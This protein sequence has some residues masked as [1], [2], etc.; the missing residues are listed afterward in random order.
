MAQV[1]TIAKTLPRLG[2]DLF[3]SV[4]QVPNSLIHSRPTRAP[5]LNG[6]QN[7]VRCSLPRTRTTAPVSHSLGVVRATVY[8]SAPW[9]LL[10]MGRKWERL[11]EMQLRTDCAVVL[12]VEPW[13]TTPDDTLRTAS[14]LTH[15]HNLSRQH[16]DSPPGFCERVRA[17]E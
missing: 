6:D 11:E 2:D 15:L 16:R 13:K 10:S 3:Q 8:T 5:M 4:G 1:P 7:R 9:I 14:H 12:A 17:A